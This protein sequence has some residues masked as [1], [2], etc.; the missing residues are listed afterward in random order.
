M[1]LIENYQKYQKE[2]F[3]T[4]K[5][6]N[7]DYAGTKGD[8]HNFEFCE[9]LGICTTEEGIVVRMCDKMTRIS[10]LLKRDAQVKDESIKDTLLDMANYAMILVSEIEDK[11]KV[12]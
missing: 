10:N 8:Y 11:N 9:K 6:K 2:M 3:D 7:A 12:K 4:L 1:S 5:R